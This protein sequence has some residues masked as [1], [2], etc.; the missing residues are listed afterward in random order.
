MISKIFNSSK[1]C[2]IND[3]TII[4]KS[5]FDMISKLLVDVIQITTYIYCLKIIKIKYL[6][7]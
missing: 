1:S 5:D 3:A 6:E 7:F 2:L 4:I